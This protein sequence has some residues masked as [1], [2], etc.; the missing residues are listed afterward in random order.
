M[1]AVSLLNMGRFSRERYVRA[2][3]ANLARTARGRRG[4]VLERGFDK[5]TTNT[6]LSGQLYEARGCVK[7]CA[8]HTQQAITIS[9]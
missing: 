6:L 2:S 4:L 9:E 1:K 7:E 5:L 3:N 8:E